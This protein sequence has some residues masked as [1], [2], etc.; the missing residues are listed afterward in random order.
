MAVA[1]RQRG[2]RILVKV[3]NWSGH[4]RRIGESGRQRIRQIR[5]TPALKIIVLVT[6]NR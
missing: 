2:G 1:G 4:A 6:A 3:E 5:Q